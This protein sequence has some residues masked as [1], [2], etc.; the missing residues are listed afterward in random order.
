MR[1]PFVFYTVLGAC[2]ASAAVATAQH[3]PTATASA[4]PLVIGMVQQVTHPA[5][6]ASARGVLDVLKEHGFEDGK[7]IKLDRQN[8]QNDIPTLAAIAKKFKDEKVD[9]VVA[10]GTLPLQNVWAVFKGTPTPVVF[11]AVTDPYAAGVAK[12]AT[13][14]GDNLTGI[15]ASPP[16]AEALQLVLEVLPRAQ[17]VGMIWTATEKNSEIATGHA[18]AAAKALHITLEEATISKADEVL[19]AAQALAAKKVEAFFIST[20]STVVSAL[21]SLVKVANDQKIPLFGN[22]SASSQRGAV[23]ALGLDYYDNG[24]NSGALL[25]KLLQGAKAKELP[26]QPQQKGQLA[27]NT[28]AA[29]LQGVTLPE[30][31]MQRV[32]ITYDTIAAPKS[33]AH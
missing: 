2:L 24:R 19:T 16:V 9:Y 5:L 30:A 22:D 28:Q 29:A 1:R 17:K 6:D 26:I 4:K 3:P 23:C 14:K 21:E 11:H 8:A 10:I 13:E 18:R 31:V 33:L 7:Q 32:E 15:Q 27:C 20:D 25:V 12:S